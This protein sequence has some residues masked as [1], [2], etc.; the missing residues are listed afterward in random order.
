MYALCSHILQLC[1]KHHIGLIKT[2]ALHQV[3][4][5][6]DMLIGMGTYARLQNEYFSHRIFFS[7]S[8]LSQE[9][10]GYGVISGSAMA[11]NNTHHTALARLL[12][13]IDC[14]QENSS[15]DI[16]PISKEQHRTLLPKGR[17]KYTESIS[18][19]TSTAECNCCYIAPPPSQ[20]I[21]FRTWM[22]GQLAIT[23]LIC[24]YVIPCLPIRQSD[25]MEIM[26]LPKLHE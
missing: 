18:T 9:Q 26:M 25:S 12:W 22:S 24:L 1:T 2:W 5:E 20:N 4:A 16:S 6:S 15:S 23:V 8:W 13:N 7:L 3:S 11:F 17:E 21:V 19:L 14:F 10:V